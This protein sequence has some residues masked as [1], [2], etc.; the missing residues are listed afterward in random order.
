MKDLRKFPS[1]GSPRFPSASSFRFQF[2]PA[3]A[4][5]LQFHPSHE[6]ARHYQGLV[7]LDQLPTSLVCIE[8]TLAFAVALCE[9]PRLSMI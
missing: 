7:Q 2:P 5:S 4:V 9:V 6:P 3:A 1:N 8:S